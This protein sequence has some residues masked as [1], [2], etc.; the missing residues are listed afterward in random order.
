MTERT[1]GER[2]VPDPLSVPLKGV[3][4]GFPALMKCDSFVKRRGVYIVLLYTPSHCREIT[5]KRNKNRKI[6]QNER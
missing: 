4:D 6:L 3:P 2:G 1:N 5:K